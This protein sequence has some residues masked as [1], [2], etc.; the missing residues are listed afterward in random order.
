MMSALLQSGLRLTSCIRAW[1]SNRCAWKR[2]GPGVHCD[3]AKISESLDGA[4]PGGEEADC[5]WQRF[6]KRALGERSLGET[7]A[8]KISE[9]CGVRITRRRAQPFLSFAS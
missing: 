4:V 8:A 2:D 1:T 6:A 7:V 9:R 5:V 3:G